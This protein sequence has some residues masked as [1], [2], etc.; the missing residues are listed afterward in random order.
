MLNIPASEATVTFL[1][2]LD[3]K[4]THRADVDA[5]EARRAARHQR[6]VLRRLDLNH[7]EE[8]EGQVYGAGMMEDD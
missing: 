6:R 4:R 8:E 5:E 2:R 7:Q 1:Q 3:D